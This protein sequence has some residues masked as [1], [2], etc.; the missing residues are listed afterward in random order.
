MSLTDTIAAI[1]TATGTGA[2]SIVRLSGIDAIEIANKGCSY[3]LSKQESHSIRY[4]KWLDPIT[5]EVMD[6]VMISLFRAP[7]TYTREDIVE[8]NCHGGPIITRQI[9]QS[10]LVYGARL[11]QPGEFTQ[12]AYLNGRID[13]TQAEATM[14][15]IEANSTLATKAAINAI[16]GSVANLLNP[17]LDKMMQ[18]ITHIEVNID[19]PEYDDVELMTQELLL[20]LAYEIKEDLIKILKQ[21]ET[22]RQIKEGVKSV[23]LGKPNVGKSSLLNAL[24]EEDK[25]IVTDIAGTTRDL[26]EGWV[27]LEA[28]TLH[29]IDTAGIRMTSDQIEQIGID[30]SFQALDEAELVIVLLDGS[31]ALSDEDRLILDKTETSNRIIVTNKKDILEH[32]HSELVISAQNQ[33]IQP[34]I[35]EINLRYQDS[36]MLLKQP[37]LGNQRQVAHMQQA[38]LYLNQALA[39]VEKGIELDIVNEDLVRCYQ[40]LYEILSPAGSVDLVSEIFSRFCL[41]K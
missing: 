26:V 41:G 5:S 34:L 11:A 13:L 37:L 36:M 6:E 22:G 20:P 24:L 21:A 3:D 17:L 30:K 19:Y 40:Q 32:R 25:A 18:I 14:D 4:G 15:L 2:I 29:L 31:E 16:S 38:L 10:L 27:R 28:I 9:L 39:E 7:K 23:I 33:Q 35:D 12:R 1:S 8:I